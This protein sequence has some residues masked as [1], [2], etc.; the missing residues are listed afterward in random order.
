MSHTIYYEWKVL[1]VWEN[2]VGLT[3]ITLSLSSQQ[4]PLI[5]THMATCTPTHDSAEQ[6]VLFEVVS[7]QL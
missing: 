2:G 6:L 5:H 7:V 3:A 4:P 1:M